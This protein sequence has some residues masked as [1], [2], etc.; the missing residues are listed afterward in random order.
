MS[1]LERDII[2]WAAKNQKA[3]RALVRGKAAVI[4][5]RYRGAAI[6]SLE[7][8]GPPKSLRGLPPLQQL[9]VVDLKAARLD[10]PSNSPDK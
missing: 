6:T 4:P 10:Q 9:F 5:L 7:S 1:K 8:K 3:A 2:D